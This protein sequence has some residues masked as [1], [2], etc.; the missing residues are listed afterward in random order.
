MA[1]IPGMAPGSSP[2]QTQE[3]TEKS[4][5]DGTGYMNRA[6]G[7]S[8]TADIT[9]S[10]VVPAISKPKPKLP[11]IKIHV[12]TSLSTGGLNKATDSVTQKIDHGFGTCLPQ[13]QVRNPAS[14]DSFNQLI[15]S[16]ETRRQGKA[17]NSNK[18]R[19][20]KPSEVKEIDLLDMDD[21]P[22]ENESPVVKL[23]VVQPEVKKAPVIKLP[24]VSP[25]VKKAPVEIS[26]PAQE[27]E[28]ILQILACPSELTPF[29]VD[30]F[31]WRKHQ[32]TEEISSMNA[33]IPPAKKEGENRDIIDLDIDD[34]A[35]Q[36]STAPAPGPSEKPKD[37]ELTLISIETETEEGESEYE[38]AGGDADDEADEQSDGELIGGETDASSSGQGV[39]VNREMEDITIET[40]DS[41]IGPISSAN[42]EQS[43]QSLIGE[44]A[45]SREVKKTQQPKET[46]SDNLIGSRWLPGQA[47]QSEDQLPPVK[48]VAVQKSA[49]VFEIKEDAD[50]LAAAAAIKNEPA[51]IPTPKG[52]APTTSVPPTSISTSPAAKVPTQ[53]LPTPTTPVRTTP[54][55]VPAPI[56]TP[57]LPQA[58]TISKIEPPRRP[59]LPM[60]EVPNF[61]IS[62]ATMQYFSGRATQDDGSTVVDENAA[63]DY[64][65]AN[66]QTHRRKTSSSSGLSPAA[67][68]FRPNL[69]SRPKANNVETP[70]RGH[71]G[72]QS[73]QHSQLTSPSPKANTNTSQ[74]ISKTIFVIEMEKR[75]ITVDFADHER[76][77]RN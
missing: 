20:P 47:V 29:A 13:P 35:R 5:N 73:S 21:E 9:K 50:V 36:S 57:T 27:L 76:D 63:P 18:F 56:T 11:D 64:G 2:N 17:S 4:N 55:P 74:Q 32:L 41:T 51:P 59:R 33:A 61:P 75:G 28:K 1:A 12:I 25:E 72:R 44:S 10:E 40:E 42:W 71:S 43:N 34:G 19:K 24:R 48:R 6:K 54:V 58:P 49:A 16:L 7:S 70:Q 37:E 46:E 26:D 69:V 66:P 3:V 8:V 53:I 45:V 65:N 62:A 14:G 15:N 39:L 31:E 23:P 38:T 68:T 60:R 30:Y 52:L 77:L 22:D 67:P